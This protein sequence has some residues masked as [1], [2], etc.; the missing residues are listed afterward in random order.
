MPALIRKST[1]DS[2]TR[3]RSVCLEHRVRG[4]AEASEKDGAQNM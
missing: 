1:T 2:E 3:K 4:G